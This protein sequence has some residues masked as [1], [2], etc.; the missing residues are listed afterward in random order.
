[1]AN[2]ASVSRIYLLVL[3]IL[4]A[5]FYVLLAACLLACG[6]GLYLLVTHLP[7]ILAHVRGRGI[8][9]VFMVGLGIVI[10]GYSLLRAMVV[11]TGGDPLGARMTRNDQPR[12]FGVLDE[13]CRKVSARPVN[14]VFVTPETEIGVWEES[15]IYMPPG[16]GKRKLVLGLAS[17]C[18]LTLDQL[19]SILAHEYGHFSNRDTYWSRF[20]ARVFA[21]VNEVR[22]VMAGQN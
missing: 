18:F 8:K 21:G 4:V 12:L 11:R 22:G 2:R 15:A 16:A 3:L 10:F 17:L 14:E 1:M 20:I 13:V 19:K 7:E 5:M 6:W 9:L